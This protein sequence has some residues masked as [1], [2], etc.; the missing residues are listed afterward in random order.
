MPSNIKIPPCLPDR[1]PRSKKIRSWN[2]DSET[3]SPL[4]GSEEG[5][6]VYSQKTRV[7]GREEGNNGGEGGGGSG[8]AVGP[9]QRMERAREREGEEEVPGSRAE[10]AAIGDRDGFDLSSRLLGN[11]A[12]RERR[13]RRKRERG[14]RILLLK[15]R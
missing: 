7:G 15:E 9:G 2:Q 6:G 12:R 8:G 3:S 5:H 11:E 13:G 1:T 10:G 4:L 14:V